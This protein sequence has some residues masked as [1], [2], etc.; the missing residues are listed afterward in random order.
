MGEG[1]VDSFCEKNAIGRF[2]IAHETR[3]I[4]RCFAYSFSKDVMK[5]SASGRIQKTGFIGLEQ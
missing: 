5:E 1:F 2:L 4:A 3:R